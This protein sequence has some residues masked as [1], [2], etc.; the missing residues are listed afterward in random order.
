MNNL[1]N[2]HLYKITLVF[3]LLFSAASGYSQNNQCQNPTPFCTANP[4]NFPAQVNAGQAQQGP[5]Y[6][7]LGGQPNPAWFFMQIATPG[8]MS[9]NI[10]STFDVDFIAWGPFPSLNGVC[11]NLTGVTQVPVGGGNN[12]CSFSGSPTETL[13]LANAQVGQFYV[14]LV[15][16]WSNQVQSINMS[17][18][19]GTGSTNCGIICSVTP[20]ASGPICPG[21]TASLSATTGTSV[22]TYTWVGPNGVISNNLNGNVVSG[23]QSNTTYTLQGSTSTGSCQAT[24]VVTVVPWPAY[25]VT[26]AT[27][28]VCQ[29]QSYLASVI[30]ANP[31]NYTYQ[32]LTG[33]PY[34][35]LTAPN[36]AGMQVTTN[37][38]S[39][40]TALAIYTVIVTPTVLNCPM[41][42]TLSLQ[43]NNPATPTLVVPAPMCNT[44]AIAVATANPPGGTWYGNPLVGPTGIIS[45]ISATS[46]TNFGLTNVN[47]SIN[48]GICT[49]SNQINISV[50]QYRSA[51]LISGIPNQCSLNNGFNL[52]NIVM[53]NT[54]GWAGVGVNQAQ[55]HFI[56]NGLLTGTYTLTYFTTSFPNPQVCPQTSTVNVQV[57]N[58]A[59]PTIAPIQP[60]C[61]NS[62]TVQLLA[63]PGGG[64]W[65]GNA[66]VNVLGWLNAANASNQTGVNSVVYTAGQGTCV[67][68]STATFNVARFNTAALTST[69][70]TLC[71]NNPTVTLMSIV[72]NTTGGTWSGINVNNNS[73]SPLGLATGTYQLTY[74]TNSTPNW[75]PALIPAMKQCTMTSTMRMTVLNPVLS[76]IVQVPPVCTADA[77]MQ[78]TVSAATGSFVPT[79]YL[80]AGGIFTPSL[81]VP[82]N[83]QVQYM[84]GTNTC[85]V[86]DSKTI[87]VEAFVPATITGIVPDQCNTG[88]VVSLLP[89]GLYPGLWSGSGVLGSSFNPAMSGVGNIIITHHTSSS[90]S[91]LCPDQKSISVA[92]YSLAAPA[93]TPEGPY[94]N[95]HAPVSIK[96]TP[97]GGRFESSSS[98]AVS[99]EGV[100]NPA[101]AAIGQNVINYSVTAGPC[102]AYVSTIVQIEEFVSADFSKYVL[103]LCKNHDPVDLNSHAQRLGGTWSGPGMLGSIFTPSNANVG[104]NNIVIYRTHS[105]TAFLCPDSSAMRITVNDV[106]NLTIVSDVKEGCAPTEVN[107]NIPNTNQ[108]E[109]TWYFG[110]GAEHNG[111]SANHIY[112]T[113]GT[114]SVVFNYWTPET[115]CSTQAT[116][117]EPLN[118][119]EVPNVAFGYGPYDEVTISDPEVQLI[120]RTPELGNNTYQWQIANMYL[121]TEINPKVTFPK[122][123]EYRI[124]LT[125][126][127]THGCKNE[128]SE[129]IVVHPD[130]NV[131][132]PNSFSPNFD[133]I[134]DEFFPVFSPFGLDQKTYE[135]EIFDRWGKQLF[136]TKD[137][138][139]GWNGTLQ[140][141]SAESMKQDV[142]VYRI[143]YK[144]LEGRIYTKI[145]NVTLVN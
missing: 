66:G 130:F 98:Y 122:T 99:P 134:N 46:P 127:N 102:I 118:I 33:S 133:G 38:I 14:V 86:V 10:S 95:S 85:N 25:I 54:G 29:S 115:R 100:F 71:F 20:V 90:P 13:I 70:M 73:F 120:N 1:I 32:W 61:T 91:G 76:T 65:T 69:N 63:T 137:I 106:P 145:G 2:K 7:C 144:D 26:P 140:N 47:Y 135:M 27:N 125:A 31:Q 67:A 45:P 78:L 97:V 104:N 3:I 4:M 16:N 18:T 35:N 42:T 9:I 56:P 60:L 28:T 49:A 79:P 21:G 103:D 101:F 12:G 112:S 30:I 23:M 116:L 36:A 142:Y 109:G 34:I 17:Q 110:D 51:Q 132:I 119:Y 41:A 72:Q 131:F 44:L 83:N 105:P 11:N 124:T 5:A 50:N 75:N 22:N 74:T 129:I 117:K 138:N 58:P 126:V 81:T 89:I 15:T 93:I 88:Q 136:F 59:T 52:M 48:I 57:F 96:A 24:T 108:G 107:F 87:S 121:L 40:P 80:T 114:Y 141:K 68:S 62:P 53:N 92:V 111:L 37:P 123:G 64:T 39:T 8:T 6:G 55:T 143:K 19:G 128:T 84:V 139:K 43:I 113:P 94:C 82:G 77:P